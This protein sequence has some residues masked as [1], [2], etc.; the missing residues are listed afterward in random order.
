[1]T[2]AATGRPMPAF[3]V[4]RGLVFAN[5]PRVSWMVQDGSEFTDGRYTVKHSEPYAGYAVRI[6]AA[7]YKPAESRVFRPG[8]ENPTFDFAL[9]RAQA[10]DLL[11]GIVLGPDGRPAAGAEVA[12]ATR[13]HPLVFENEQFTFGRGNGM[14]FAKTGPDGRFTFDAPGGPFLLAATSDDGYAEAK[15]DDF[16]KSGTLAMKAWGKVSGQAMIGRKPAANE[17]I[18]FSLRDITSINTAVHAFHHI[19][20]RTDAQG[21]FS[22]DRVIP[23]QSEVARV[24]VTDFGNGMQQH[25]GCWQEPVDVAPGQSVEVRIGGKGRPVVGRVA[26]QAPPGVQVDWRRNRPA[27]IEK[28]RVFNPLRGIFGLVDPHAN[29]RFAASLDKDGRFRVEDVPPGRYEL[30]VTIDAPPSADR[31]GP[32]RELGQ[33]KVPV[34]V[35]EGD[36][37]APVDL[38]EI[39]A[40]VKG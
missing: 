29:D 11:T 13:D 19:S 38:G 4:I 5:N 3:R 12:L 26:L 24:V 15:P 23:G 27:T 32:T 6:E 16:A 7:G 18:S 1:M 33:V 34:D 37:D 30:T 22:F 21:R 2:D 31:P 28:P 10:A 17:L 40:E 39:P 35:P 9:S 20:A 36:A 25:M 8:E 14:S